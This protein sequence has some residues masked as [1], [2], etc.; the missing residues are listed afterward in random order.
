VL[1]EGEDVPKAVRKDFFPWTVDDLDRVLPRLLDNMKFTEVR[2]QGA[3][4]QATAVAL[5][6]ASLGQY[7][8]DLRLEF[9][10]KWTTQSDGL[11]VIITVEEHQNEWTGCL[12]NR[13]S[14]SL[15]GCL[16]TVCEMERGSDA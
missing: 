15:I 5:D 10:M 4:G 8:V 16:K 13:L 3:T 9:S 12:C 11:T 6:R 7:L 1:H 14:D 2:I